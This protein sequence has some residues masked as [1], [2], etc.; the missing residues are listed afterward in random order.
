M[1]Q[2]LNYAV[3]LGSH[4]FATTNGARLALF[5]TPEAGEPF[6]IDTH[7]LLVQ[8]PFRLEEKNVEELLGF[9][10]K[11]HAGIPVRLVEVDWFFI[12][13]LRSFVVFNIQQLI[14][15]FF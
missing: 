4:A 2:A 14:K 15:P 8:D 9:L 11:W 6:R 7:R 1:N 12:S 13:R 10:A 5:R 3:R